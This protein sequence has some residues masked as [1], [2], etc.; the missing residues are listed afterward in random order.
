MNVSSDNVQGPENVSSDNVQGFENVSSVSVQVS[1]NVLSDNVQG[2]K[3]FYLI[4]YRIVKISHL[5]RVM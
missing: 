2:L 5:Y 3:S 4:M 1:E